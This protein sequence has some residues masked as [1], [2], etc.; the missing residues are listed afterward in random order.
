MG[1][2]K[3]NIK[4]IKLLLFLLS[5]IT[6][7]SACGKSLNFQ[8]PTDL[9]IGTRTN[10]PTSTQTYTSTTNPTETLT[11]TPDI[12]LTRETFVVGDD[13]FEYAMTQ[14]HM[15]WCAAYHASRT[16]NLLDELLAELENRIWEEAWTEL[17]NTQE[18]WG[19]YRDQDCLW[20]SNFVFGGS[21]EP[22]R[23]GLCFA[24]HNKERLDSLKLLLCEGA[25]MTGPCEASEYYDVAF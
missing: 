25:G 22:L 3:G 21:I 14:F 6:S 15:N 11:S 13:C 7:L 2:R 8:T 20:K 4:N 24:V 19:Q 10:S 16:A 5:V 1:N 12:T 17:Q 18:I 9:S 23:R